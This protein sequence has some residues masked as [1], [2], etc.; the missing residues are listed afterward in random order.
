MNGLIK[1]IN[2]ID[3]PNNFLIALIKRGVESFVPHGNTEIKLGD[4]IVFYE[5]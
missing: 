3:F 5:T 1:K 2:E 4:T